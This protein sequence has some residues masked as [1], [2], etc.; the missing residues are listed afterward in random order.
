MRA[1]IGLLAVVLGLC[2]SVAGAD[3]PPAAAAAA[4]PATA[5]IEAARAQA[6][7]AGVQVTDL[8]VG[9]GTPALPPG[10]ARVHYTG[11]LYDA[12]A[13]DGK[14]RQFDSSLARDQPF[15]FDLGTGQVIKGWDLGVA[16]MQPGGERR[17]VIPPALA[18]G[19][20]GASNGVIPPNA[21]LVFDIQLLGFVA[22]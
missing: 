18:Y 17:L 7:A 11:W 8:K 1:P 2:A 6:L 21:T 3:Q 19:I 4:S 22:Q 20:R 10:R 15:P 12:S 5:A 14:G 16:G 13:K 9:K